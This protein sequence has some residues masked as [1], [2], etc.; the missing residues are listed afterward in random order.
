MKYRVICNLDIAFAN[1]ADATSLFSKIK[2]GVGQTRRVAQLETNSVHLEVH[3]CYHDEP[4]PRPCEPIE[5][6]DALPT[7]EE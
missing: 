1:A 3:R 5:S 2:K 6:L 4:M 7:G